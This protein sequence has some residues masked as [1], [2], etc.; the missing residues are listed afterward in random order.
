MSELADLVAIARKLNYDVTERQACA[1]VFLE[2]LENRTFSGA[3]IPFVER[4]VEYAKLF[5]AGLTGDLA[6][7]NDWARLGPSIRQLA[8][9]EVTMANSGKVVSVISEASKAGMPAM[10]ELVTLKDK[11]STFATS[12][13]VEVVSGSPAHDITTAIQA[14]VQGGGITEDTLTKSQAVQ[15]SVA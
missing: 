11:A 2:E 14:V 10:A 3:D 4:V 6:N 8:A 12:K 1:E 9:Q 5:G 7:L 13:L 15:A